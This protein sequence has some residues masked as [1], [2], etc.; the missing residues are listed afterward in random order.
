MKRTGFKRK[1]YDELK[2]SVRSKMP[3]SKKIKPKK[4]KLPS[5]KKL[6]QILTKLSHDFVR[7]RDSIMPPNIGG[8]CF[9]CGM[10]ASGSNFQSGHYEPSSTCGALLRW[11][12]LNMHGQCGYKCNINRHGQQKMAN[13]YT[14]RMISLYGLEKVQELRA[15]KNRLIQ[16]DRYFLTSMIDLYKQGNQEEIIKFLDNYI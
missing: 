6:K 8:Y 5:L 14:M 15:M 13:E 2:A 7:E 1:S 16:C 3:R 4:V 12:P 9:T 11:H 10:L